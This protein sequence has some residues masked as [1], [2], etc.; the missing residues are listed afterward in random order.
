MMKFNIESVIYMICFSHKQ[1][2]GGPAKYLLLI[3]ICFYLVHLTA[4]YLESGPKY[5][6]QPLQLGNHGNLSSSDLGQKSK[7]MKGLLVKLAICLWMDQ[8]LILGHV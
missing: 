5:K 3:K 4:S 1:A 7:A 2:I 8:A 6:T